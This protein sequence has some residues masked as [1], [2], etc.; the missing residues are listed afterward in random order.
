[1]VAVRLAAGPS[2][3][4]RGLAQVVGANANAGSVAV[5]KIPSRF[6]LYSLAY[7]R[8]TLCLEDYPYHQ[9]HLLPYTVLATNLLLSTTLFMTR[10]TINW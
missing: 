10:F 8:Q 1:M 7:Y 3:V 2:T 9:H 4:F 5:V 6:Q